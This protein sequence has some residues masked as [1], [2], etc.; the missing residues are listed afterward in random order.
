MHVPAA[1]AFDNTEQSK[2]LEVELTTEQIGWLREKAEK[3]N[4]SLNHV[5]RSMITAQMRSEDEYG[6]EPYVPSASGDGQPVFSSASADESSDAPEDDGSSSIVESLRSANE[7]L[8]DLTEQD[9][10]AESPTPADTLERLQVRL[11][12]TSDAD[13]EDD[14]QNSYVVENQNRSMFDMMEDE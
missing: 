11:G 14:A 7:R 1:D 10:V 3:Q 6:E 8:Q 9:E 13:A 5:L 4:L 2:S 12:N